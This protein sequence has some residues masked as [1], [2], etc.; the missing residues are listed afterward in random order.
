MVQWSGKVF[1]TS[2]TTLKNTIR[3][4]GYVTSWNNKAYAGLRS[5][6]S[7]F[8]YVDRV[9]E[10]IEPLESKAKLSQQEIWEI[11]KNGCMV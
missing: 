11:N 7:N 3:K 1:M 6:S 5:D 8:S 2:H 9:N 10:L 4:S